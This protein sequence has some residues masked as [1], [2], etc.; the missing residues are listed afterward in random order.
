MTNGVTGI[1]V[2]ETFLNSQK[3]RITNPMVEYNN[4]KNTPLQKKN[5]YPHTALPLLLKQLVPKIV[6]T[7]SW[8]AA[9]FLVLMCEDLS[10]PAICIVVFSVVTMVSAPQPLRVETGQSAHGEIV[11]CACNVEIYGEMTA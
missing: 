11:A 10:I 3:Y 5:V 7:H 6:C 1:L 4:L 9:R 8:A 2:S